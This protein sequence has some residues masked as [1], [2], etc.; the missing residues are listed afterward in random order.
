MAKILRS[1]T[2]Q[3]L[4]IEKYPK[5]LLKIIDN[6]LKGKSNIILKYATDE[7]NKLLEPYDVITGEPRFDIKKTFAEGGLA[8]MF[9]R[10]G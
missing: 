8:S 1:P 4:S 9:T 10:R 3:N 5:N 2:G 6:L 7:V